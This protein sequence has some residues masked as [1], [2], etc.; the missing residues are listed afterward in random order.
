MELKKKEARKELEDYLSKG[1]CEKLGI[2]PKE[3]SNNKIVI[4]AMNTE[5]TEVVKLK[6]KIEDELSIPTEIEQI[7]SDDWEKWF[8]GNASLVGLEQYMNKKIESSTERDKQNS[9]S[10]NKQGD[11]VE[12]EEEKRTVENEKDTSETQGLLFDEIEAEY[13]AEEDYGATDG[14]ES[15]SSVM[16]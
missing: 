2:L 4:G 9:K 12:K 14:A 5:Y 6:K 3:W 1:V 11:E 7:T 15:L 8:E 16:K 10:K 13:E